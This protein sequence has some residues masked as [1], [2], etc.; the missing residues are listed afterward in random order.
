MRS[1]RRSLRYIASIL[2]VTAVA[3]MMSG[4]GGGSKGTPFVAVASITVSPSSASLNFGDTLQFSATALD[5]NKKPVSPVFTFSSSNPNIVGMTSAG[6]A[7]GGRW[8]SSFV[9][10]T[11]G[12]V[13]V[14]EITASAS[15]VTSPP[16]KVF[17]HQKVNSVSITPASVNCL[18][19]GGQQTFT[20][21]AFNNTLGDI[22][23]TVGQFTW[24]AVDAN[25]ALLNSSVTGLTLNQAVAT[26]NAPGKTGVFASISGVN[27]VPSPFVTCPVQSISLVINNTP[28]KTSISVA[29]GTPV[30]IT[31]TVVDSLGATIAPS[32]TF[33]S[34]QQGVATV[35][36]H[37]AVTAVNPGTTT[38]I[39]SCT[40]PLCNTNLNP[41]YPSNVVT[42]TI[43][44]TVGTFNVWATSSGC[45]GKPGCT[46][47]MVPIVTP[48]NTL[49]T[50][51]S[52][53]S[54]PNSLMFDPQGKTGFL[55]SN[56][57]LMIVDMTKTPPTV[58]QQPS[59]PGKVL[60]VSQDGTKVLISNTAVV[61]NNVFVFSTTTSTATPLGLGGVSAGDFSPDSLKAFV[62]NGSLTSPPST[63]D[64]TV[65]SALFA[66]TNLILSGANPLD[67]TFLPTGGFGYVAGGAPSAVT[68]R[69][70]CDTSATPDFVDTISMSATPLLIR[71]L[72]DASKL[73]VLDSLNNIDV[74][75]PTLNPPTACPP[76]VVDRVTSSVSLTSQ[77]L[78]PT[79]MLVATDS[80]RAY[81]LSSLPELLVY[82]V[83]ANTASTIPLTGGAI[84]LAGA[85]R[86]D[87][88]NIF[89]GASDGK[90]HQ[91]NVPL[92]ADV[93]QVG[94]LNICSS[95]CTPN[96]VALQP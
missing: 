70:T 95:G 65:F 32:L 4:C 90:V 52:L 14:A 2:L 43:T 19:R 86:P 15:G 76:T 88:T 29:K 48:G 40:P 23:S 5:S 66:Q 75:T 36:I 71:A 82:N 91:V 34:S 8:D 67:V 6:L 61:P 30:S 44:G 62:V 92:Q 64:L 53:P 37:G 12:P 1:S 80:S 38:I 18:S 33:T 59:T 28:G 78:T 89:V 81:V 83:G 84:P 7:C 77:S 47:S 79:Q 94:S 74:I 31:P 39:A 20:A 27:S 60:A 17:V 3:V 68:V 24:A 49:G 45:T 22:T 93:G 11:A 57:G 63:P 26:A 51:V 16:V 42:V 25:V 35:G 46:T 13:G 50:A 72:P 55:G 85:L 96:I 56:A 69:A 41:T 58:S 87:N 21:S 54:T 10:C 73:L 9:N